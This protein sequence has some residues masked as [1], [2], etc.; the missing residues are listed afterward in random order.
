V[1]IMLLLSGSSIAGQGLL[2]ALSPNPAI[3]SLFGESGAIPVFG[4][5]DGGRC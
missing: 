4:A 5:G 2:S 3:L 1:V